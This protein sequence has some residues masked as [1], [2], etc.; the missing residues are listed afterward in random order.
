[1]AGHSAQLASSAPL[2]ELDEAAIAARVEHI[3]G[4]AVRVKS[5]WRDDRAIFRECHRPAFTEIAVDM[6]CSPFA[7]SRTSLS[8]IFPVS[9]QTMPRQ[10]GSPRSTIAAAF[11]PQGFHTTLEA[12][13]SFL[14]TTRRRHPRSSMAHFPGVSR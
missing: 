3:N 7:A 5:R 2:T 13:A 8:A 12:A 6:R 1:M 10:A 11:S 4:T 9:T 14:M